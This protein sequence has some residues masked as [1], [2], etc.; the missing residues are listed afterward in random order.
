MKD[1]IS[2]QATVFPLTLSEAKDHLN[3]FHSEDDDQISGMIRAATFYVE[4]QMQVTMGQKTWELYLDTVPE[5]SIIRLHHPPVSS[6][7]KIEYYAVG[8]SDLTE[9]STDNVILDDIS[10]PCEIHLRPYASWFTPEDRV[11]AI[12]VTYKA[13]YSSADDIPENWKQAVKLV[14][15]HFYYNRGDEGHRAIIRTVHDLIFNDS[16]ITV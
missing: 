7:D 1:R 6:L 16:V 9:F 8:D 13:G 4:S 10:K 12:K 11:N 5:D 15:G 14:V 2:V 3:V